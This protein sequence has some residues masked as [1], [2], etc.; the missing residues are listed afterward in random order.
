[1]IYKCKNCGG[2]VVYDPD[3][4]KMYCPHCDGVDSEEETESKTITE[5]AN[6]GAPLEISNYTSACKCAHCG[7]Y[8]ILEERVEGELAPHLILPFQISKKK[9]VELLQ[10]EFQSR[11][12]TPGTFLSAA[13]L[14]G[15][16]GIYVPFFLYD[17]LGTYEYEGTGTK[18]RS[19]RSGNTEYIE[20]SYF[21]V[22]RNMEI[23]FDRIPVDASINMDNRAMDMMEPF[24]SKAM[25]NFQKK[26]MSG[27]QGECFSEGLMELEPRAQVKAQHDAEELLRET[28]TGYNA[29][30]GDRKHLDLKR[31]TARY[32]L[33]PVWVYH[34]SYHGQKY[35][36]YVN[37]QSG[38]ILGKTPV[39]RGKVFAYGSTVWAF[40]FLMLML[41]KMILEVL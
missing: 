38:K 30:H 31:Q 20:T 12:F 29:L 5:C 23:D 8:T 14:E 24:E 10:K 25:E 36:Y 39:S 13:T 9:A 7:Y 28:L 35:D 16:E 26:Y 22:E 4:K 17:Y 27:F 2:N 6:C 32:A 40:L 11:F 33:L 15:M 34:Y 37:G 19:W 1:M 3:K 21:H 18:I 41:G